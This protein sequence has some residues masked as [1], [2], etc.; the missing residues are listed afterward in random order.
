MAIFTEREIAYLRQQRLGRLATVGKDGTVQNNP[1]GFGYNDALQTI[2]IGGHNMAA[3]Q[4]FRYVAAGS[5]VSFVVDDIASLNP[6]TVRCLEIRGDAQALAE[7][8]N[9]AAHM[10]GPIIRVHPRRI[11][12]FGIDPDNPAAGK[13]TVSVSGR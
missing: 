4:K 7:P 10:G 9:S 2:D 12:S 3:S 6:W 13:R 1:V 11:I 5:K 8:T